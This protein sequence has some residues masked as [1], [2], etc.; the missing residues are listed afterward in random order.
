MWRVASR[1]AL[2]ELVLP[3]VTLM[4][5]FENFTCLLLLYAIIISLYGIEFGVNAAPSKLL[6]I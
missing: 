5:I 3:N 4:R 1:I 2:R 6:I